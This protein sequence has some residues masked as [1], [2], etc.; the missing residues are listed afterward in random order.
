MDKSFIQDYLIEQVKKKTPTLIGRSLSINNSKSKIIAIVGPRR[1]GKTS[2]FLKLFNK[3]KDIYLNFEDTRLIDINFRDIRKIIQVF[4]EIFRKEP[5]NLFLDEIQNIDGWEHS[6]RELLDLK[7]YEI[8]ITGSSSKL[9]GSE[10]STSLRG[11]SFSYYLFPFSFKEFLVAKN[12]KF[13]LLTN[14]EKSRIKGYLKEYMEWGGFP[15]IVILGEEKERI[16]KDYFDAIFF[17]DF[18]ERYQLKNINLARFLMS[19]LFQNFS[20]EISVNKIYN[21][22]KS[23]IS[24][25]KTT[26]YDYVSK[27]P[28]S[29]SVFFISRYSTKIYQRESWPKKVYICDTG[30]AKLSK[31]SS[32]IGKLMENIVYL[33]LKRDQNNYPLQEIYYWKDSQKHEVDFLLKEG[34]IVKQLIQVTYATSLGKIEQREIRSLLKASNDFNCGNLLIITWDFESIKEIKEKKIMFVPLWSWLLKT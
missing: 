13:D 10:I 15:E 11:R 3:S 17:R 26:L 29:M 19:H 24:F 22:I 12:I 1:S 9:L 27:L 2:Y 5:R 34:N 16:L 8:F 31:F 6:V 23:Q 21:F 4:I 32:D 25:G 7:K 20:N 28:D 30:L 33:Q 18:I 14:D